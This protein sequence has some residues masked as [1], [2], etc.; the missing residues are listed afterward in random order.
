MSAVD[1]AGVGSITVIITLLMDGSNNTVGLYN[2]SVKIQFIK[3]YHCDIIYICR[4]R[5]IN[6]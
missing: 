3:K 4:N 6:S 5:K 2:D 1:T